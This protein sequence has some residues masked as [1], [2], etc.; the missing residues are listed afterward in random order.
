M[1]SQLDKAR[2]MSVLAA[3]ADGNWSKAKKMVMRRMS[4]R[5]APPPFRGKDSAPPKSPGSDSAA[6]ASEPPASPTK[7][8]LL[9]DA[10][11]E[12]G[13]DS[14]SEIMSMVAETYELEDI[15]VSRTRNPVKLQLI[16][17]LLLQHPDRPLDLMY[18]TQ[19]MK[20]L[21]VKHL[22]TLDAEHIFTIC[23][24]EKGGK[25]ENER[26]MELQGFAHALV[27]N[28]LLMICPSDQCATIGSCR[29]TVPI[30]HP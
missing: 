25:K 14:A 16:V 26:S 19:E 29:A 7:D 8:D 18:M 13:T 17:M 27:R 1:E 30:P 6:A 21:E 28:T 12:L 3:A 24:S 2:S 22:K 4:L 5:Q 20:S 11:N 15:G 23:I 9:T 10:E